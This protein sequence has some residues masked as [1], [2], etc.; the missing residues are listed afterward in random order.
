V[1][2]ADVH[3]VA[4]TLKRAIKAVGTPAYNEMVRNCMTQDLSWKVI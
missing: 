3:K 1:E 4:T 2:P